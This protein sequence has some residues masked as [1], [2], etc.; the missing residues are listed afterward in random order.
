MRIG[1]IVAGLVLI[2][3]GAAAWMG[4]FEYTKDKE[5]AKIGSLSATVATD[6][7]VPQWIGGI[8]VLVGIGLIAAGAM[9][10]N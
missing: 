2:I 4:K 9:R 3:A 1:L 5:V 8:G 10:K 7:T 6:K